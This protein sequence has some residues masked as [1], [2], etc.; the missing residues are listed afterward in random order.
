MVVAKSLKQTVKHVCTS[1]VMPKNLLT[2]VGHA[3]VLWLKLAC[4]E[5]AF[6]FLKM[7]TI[8]DTI[9][10]MQWLRRRPQT[11]L[12]CLATG[13]Y[14]KRASI[15][16]LMRRP[17]GRVRDPKLSTIWPSWSSKILLKFHDGTNPYLSLIHLKKGCALDP[18]MW[19]IVVIGKSKLKLILQ[20]CFI[21]ASLRNSCLK[22]LDG[23]ASTVK[24]LSR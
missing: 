21:F 17:F 9:L 16:F 5:R 19:V 2:I 12:Y 14:S 18:F 1:V 11:P 13:L 4:S 20:N 15:D 22:S 7:R 24:P 23:T 8:V 6:E 3:W 10:K